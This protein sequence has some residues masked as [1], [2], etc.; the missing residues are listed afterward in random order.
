MF[1]TLLALAL[2]ASA[3]TPVSHDLRWTLSVGDQVVGWRTANVK[4]IPK[5]DGMMRMITGFTDIDGK[6]GPMGRRFRQNFTVTAGDSPANFKSAMEENGSP[7]EMQLV[8]N[9]TWQLTKVNTGSARTVS[10]PYG[11]VHLS[12]FDLL[13]PDSRAPLSKFDDGQT[14]NILFAETGDVLAGTLEQLGNSDLTIDKRTV[15]VMGYAWN[16]AQGRSEFFYSN[17]G[18]LV[19][20]Q[21]KVWGMRLQGILDDPPPGGIDEFAVAVDWPPIEEIDL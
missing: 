18:Y 15:P 21:M 19:K 10:Y 2:S 8:Y 1:T 5:A 20:Y 7:Y 9:N 16:G 3:A 11:R 17:D 4:F 13:D 14:L 12:T 6:V